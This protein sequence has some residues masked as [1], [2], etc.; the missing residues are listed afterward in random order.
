MSSTLT[1]WIVIF[2]VGALTYLSRLSFIALFARYAMPPLVTRALRFVPAAM[3]AAIVVPAVVIPSADN[4]DPTLATAK[5]VAAGIAVLVAW[6]WRN[7]T[8]TMVLGM[9]ALWLSQWMLGAAA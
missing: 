2:A 9:I 5:L 6:R 1:L 4:P 3:L 7:A 8:L